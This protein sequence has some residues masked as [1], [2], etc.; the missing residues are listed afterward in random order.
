[1]ARKADISK[2]TL[3]YLEQG[4]GN[5]AIDTLW[6][7]A[8]AL[9]VPIGVLFVDADLAAI[10][11]L[12]HEEAPV[13][14]GRDHANDW[15]EVSV[16]SHAI[17][18]DSGFVPRHLLSSRPGGQFEIYWIDMKPNTKRVAMQHSTG[19]FEH[20]VPV[21]GKIQIAVDGCVTLLDCGDRMSFPAD[22]THCYETLE[23]GARF[24]SLLD[25]P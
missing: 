8:R 7:L 17:E 5:P 18:R 1:L 19:V 3:S 25:Y 10:A 24:I 13:L 23:D 22:R 9:A 21:A 16:A 2:S 20:V 11:V 15:R 6:A 14:V 4:R 12:R